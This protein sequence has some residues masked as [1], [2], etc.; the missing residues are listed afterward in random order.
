VTVGEAKVGGDGSLRA[1]VAGVRLEEPD[2]VV[3]G[4]EG[5][6]AGADLGGVEDLVG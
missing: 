1:D 3:V 4:V 6:E 2:L 5:R